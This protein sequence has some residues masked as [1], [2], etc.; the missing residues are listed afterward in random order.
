MLCLTGLY[1]VTCLRLTWF[2]EWKF[3]A[4]AKQVYSVVSLYNHTYGVREVS[5]NWRYIGV[6]NFYRLLSGRETLQE[7]PPAPLDA[8]V[9]PPGKPL[10]V[11]FFPVDIPFIRS[12]KLKIVYH[13]DETDAAVAIR[14]EVESAPCAAGA[15]V[16][17]A[18]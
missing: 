7:V 3:N 18:R 14:P 17:T 16:G 12:E 15:S 8:G 5:A 4:D 2:Q 10:Y 6:L 1:F 13:N 11:L 9:Y